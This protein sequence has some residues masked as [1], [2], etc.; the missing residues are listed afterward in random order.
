M[1]ELPVRVRVESQIRQAAGS[2]GSEH[3]LL[4]LEQ[5]DAHGRSSTAGKQIAIR[6]ITKVRRFDAIMLEWLYEY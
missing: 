3:E 6:M 2:L 4:A 5:V 1:Q